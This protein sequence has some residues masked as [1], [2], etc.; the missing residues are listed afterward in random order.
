MPCVAP[1]RTEEY[2]FE[3]Y[4]RN[5]RDLK[6]NTDTHTSEM[7]T[8]INDSSVPIQRGPDTCPRQPFVNGFL[9]EPNQH[10]ND[11]YNRNVEVRDETILS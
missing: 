9:A 7:T 3:K 5:Y 6:K 4:L 11:Q 1:R 10:I 8:V 2:I